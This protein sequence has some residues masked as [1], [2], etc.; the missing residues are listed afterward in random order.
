MVVLAVLKAGVLPGVVNAY[1]FDGN[2]QTANEGRPRWPDGVPVLYQFNQNV[3]DAL[4]QIVAPGGPRL[5][6][7]QSFSEWSVSSAI[8]IGV[9]PDTAIA[10]GGVMDGVNLVTFEDTPLNQAAVGDFLAVTFFWTNGANQIVE[11]DI[12]FS[13]L[14]TFSTSGVPDTFPI[15]PLTAHEIGHFI[16]LEHSGVLAATMWPFLGYNGVVT[17]GEELSASLTHDDRAGA[18]QLYPFEPFLTQ[19]GAIAGRVTLAAAPV[20]GAQVV[21]ASVVDGIVF[22]ANLTLGSNQAENFGRF[23]IDGLPPGDYVIYAE[24]MDGPADEG[25]W[26]GGFD[27]G[28]YWGGT[29]TT[30]FQTT[31]LG[32]NASPTIVTVIAGLTEEIELNVV[33]GAPTL[34][35]RFT[36]FSPTGTGFESS[37]RLPLDIRPGTRRHVVIIG[38]GVTSVPDS[39][40]SCSDPSI[41]IDT[42]NRLDGLTT[43]DVPFSIFAVTIPADSPGGARNFIFRLGAEVAAFTGVLYVNAPETFPIPVVNDAH[44]SWPRYR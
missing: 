39:G 8:S 18:N 41:T 6:I 10:D 11:S 14:E 34:N 24:P 21:A 43:T 17:E 7:A 33:A 35:P 31:F 37:S 4:P 9:G 29:F 30:G 22:G 2:D 16:G 44:A 5:A 25:N 15:S 28:S 26:S 12:V 20:Y 23:Q 42:S 27:F 38:E 36:A 19:A 40:I 32:G 13:A 1:N 3:S